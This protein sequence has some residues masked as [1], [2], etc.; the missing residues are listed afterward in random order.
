MLTMRDGSE[1]TCRYFVN[2]VA[3]VSSLA[4]ALFAL[5]HS[6]ANYVTEAPRRRPVNIRDTLK[7]NGELGFTCFGG[8]PVYFQIV[9]SNLNV[10]E[11]TPSLV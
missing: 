5:P 9:S 10:V 7:K 2:I 11:T 6:I 3:R 1:R 8:P 4:Q